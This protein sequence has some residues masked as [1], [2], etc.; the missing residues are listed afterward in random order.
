V[1]R[2]ALLNL[3]PAAV[4]AFAALAPAGEKSF[5][6]R[7]AAAKSVKVQTDI[8][9]VGI[10][11]SLEQARAKFDPLAPPHGRPEKEAEKEEE[12]EQKLLWKLDKSNFSSVFVK[13][14]AS[15]RVTY[16]L[17]SLRPGQEIP[18]AQIGEVEKAPIHND[19]VVAWDVVRENRLL[20]RVV[21]KGTN[22][23]AE[24]IT[25][26]LVKRPSHP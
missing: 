7:L 8:L 22:H 5:A 18:F 19:K 11:S 26:F 21:A 14:D 6:E 15:E 13:A 4:V 25:I 3:V 12:G 2:W 20:V 24:S 23:K 9:G 17:G 1:R 10:D 16:L